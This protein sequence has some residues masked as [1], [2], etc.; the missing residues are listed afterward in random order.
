[1]YFDA[2]KF[3]KQKNE[4]EIKTFIEKGKLKE[5]VAIAPALQE[6]LKKVTQSQEKLN[7][8]ELRRSGMKEEH[9]KW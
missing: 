1:M 7:Y 8:R 9:W 5:F 3:K 2:Q 4:G 6:M